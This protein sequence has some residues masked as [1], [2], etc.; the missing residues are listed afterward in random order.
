MHGQG[1][2]YWEDGE[3]PAYIGE[4]KASVRDGQGESFDA[5]GESVYKGNWKNDKPVN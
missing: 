2:L 1:T 4:W 3:T 5:E